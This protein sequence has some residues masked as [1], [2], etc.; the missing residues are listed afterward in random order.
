MAASHD[1]GE[2]YVLGRDPAEL[3]RLTK[4]H[5]LLKTELGGRLVLAPL[6]L[7]GP[8]LKILDC[9]CADGL[10]LRELCQD[11]PDGA[12]H[13]YVGTDIEFSYFPKSPEASFKY[14]AQSMQSPFPGSWLNSFD[15]VHMRFGLAAAADVGPQKVVSNFITAV[16]PG[17]WIQLVE[18]D[19]A[20]TSRCGPA[21][22]ETFRFFAELFG[23]M[24]S[25]ADYASKMSG[26]FTQEGLK[27]VSSETC[28]VRMGK[29]NPDPTMAAVSVALQNHI[30]TSLV[31]LALNQIPVSTPRASLETLAARTKEELESAGGSY[32]MK[33]VWGQKA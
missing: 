18:V 10:W 26:W 11:L 1:E 30:T 7:N 23:K 2:D 22:T 25:G 29:A 9:A 16:K 3:T 14:V 12:R 20:D 13:S 15:L 5:T 8:S 32:C 24:G 33:V 28:Y 17:G 19:W 21:L 6:D 27:N 4:Q 31:G